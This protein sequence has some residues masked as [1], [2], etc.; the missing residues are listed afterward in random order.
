[1]FHKPD[2]L[3]WCFEIY[4]LISAKMLCI[5]ETCKVNLDLWN[6]LFHDSYINCQNEYSK[7]YGFKIIH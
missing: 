7:V 5:S 3:K 4:A 1:M 6:V 2:N